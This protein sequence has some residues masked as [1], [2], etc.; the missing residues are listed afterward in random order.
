LSTLILP[1]ITCIGSCTIIP[2]E[3]IQTFKNI[4]YEF[5]WKGKKDPVK[6]SVSSN[7]YL[8]GGLKMTNIDTYIKALQ[9]KWILRLLENGNDNWKIIPQKYFG[10]IGENFLIF[11]MNLHSFK[12]LENELTKNIPAFYK[13]LLKTWITCRGR[14]N[15]SPHN[16][17][18]IRKQIIRGNKYIK[19]KGKCLVKVNWIKSGI[20]FINDILYEYGHIS[21]YKII[22]KLRNKQNWIS[23]LIFLPS[24][25]SPCFQ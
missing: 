2:K 12:S 22:A 14:E 16:F 3:Y 1:N 15:K 8:E 6:R 10:N 5:L 19:Y 24:T 25:G 4:V 21:E 9:I 20:I 11:N 13:E 17:R 18:E 23:E 7:D